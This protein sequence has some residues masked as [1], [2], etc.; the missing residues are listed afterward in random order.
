MRSKD[1]E[2]VNMLPQTLRLSSEALPSGLAANSTARLLNLSFRDPSVRLTR[3]YIDTKVFQKREKDGRKRRVPVQ[4]LQLEAAL[5]DWAV[6]MGY[7]K[8]T[9]TGDLIRSA[10]TQLWTRMPEFNDVKEPN[11][12]RVGFKISN[13]GTTSARE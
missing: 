2:F 10:A 13:I 11:G 12:Q 8:L 1:N 5:F 9:A 3:T 7:E 4:H 6:T